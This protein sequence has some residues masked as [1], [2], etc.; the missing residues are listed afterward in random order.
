ML[1]DDLL[2]ENCIGTTSTAVI[3]R[4]CF[5][6]VG[7]FDVY[8]RG[9]QDWDLWIRIAREFPIDY[10][11]RPLVRFLNHD[12]RITH[13]LDAKIQGK[14]RLFNKIFTYIEEKPKIISNHLFVIGYLYCTKG[15]VKTG[16]KKIFEA[17]KKHPFK[18]KYY[19]YFI[20]S[21]LGVSCYKYLATLK[22]LKNTVK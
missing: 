8:L 1:D 6:K 13:D 4:E 11:A 5:D 21:L 12:I 15:D 16:R 9:S 17:L 7:G 2:T 10:V 22:I 20:P 14:E 18:I 3:R 19:K